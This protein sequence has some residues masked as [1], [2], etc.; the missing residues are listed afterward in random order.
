MALGNVECAEVGKELDIDEGDEL[1]VSDA[2]D[3]GDS[4]TV[5]AEQLL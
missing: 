5:M 3:V 1:G 4:E 2:V